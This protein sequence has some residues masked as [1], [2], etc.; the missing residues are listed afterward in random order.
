ME[1]SV[2]L[3]RPPCVELSME[4]A[5][6]SPA[7]TYPVQERVLALPASE[8]DSGKSL[9]ASLEKPAQRGRSS[10]TPHSCE[11]EDWKS[12]WPTLPRSGTMRNGRLTERPMLVPLTEGTACGSWPTPRKCSAM[13][14][15]ITQESAH[16]PGRFPNL[17]TVVGRAIYATPSK[18]HATGGVA[19][20]GDAAHYRVLVDGGKMSYREALTITRGAI[21]HKNMPPWREADL[22]SHIAE[23]GKIFSGDGRGGHLNPAWV[24]WLMGWP[25]EWTALPLL[26]TAGFRNRRRKRSDNCGQGPAREAIS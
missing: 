7:R 19:N 22:A 20:S 25:I 3:T 4:Y 15:T 26:A 13:A 17:E 18:C 21:H 9:P 1:T 5:A 6:D 10:K 16:A 14:A 2:P 8:A 12:S 24:E 23:H 11:L